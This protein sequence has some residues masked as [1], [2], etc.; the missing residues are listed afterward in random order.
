VKQSDRLTLG[1]MMDSIKRVVVLLDAEPDGADTVDL[2][3][4][5]FQMVCLL[6]STLFNLTFVL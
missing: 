6:Y 5:E 3:L 2:V 4:P 1:T